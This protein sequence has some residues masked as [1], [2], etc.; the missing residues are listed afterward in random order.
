M[1]EPGIKKNFF[2]FLLL[3]L[4]SVLFLLLGK[5]NWFA[6]FLGFLRRPLN[7]LESGSL[8]SYQRT[9][10]NLS[11]SSNNQQ[12]TKIFELEGRLRQL[13]V[14]QNKLSL[15]QE[16]NDKLKRLLGASLPASWQFMDARVLGI[17][18][19]IK[20]ARGLRDGVKQGMMVVAEDIL[21]GKVSE[22]DSFTSL[23]QIITNSNSK[24]PV[25]IKRPDN[26]GVQAKGLLLGQSGQTLILDKVLQAESIQKG[27]LVATSGDE[28]WLPDLL[29]GQ[30]KEVMPKSAEV[31]QKASVSP[32]INYQDLRIV[33][34]I[35]Q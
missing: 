4:V 6:S 16:E 3:I 27:D 30:I 21:V 35:I 18:D 2:L 32:L 8:A 1:K 5:Q 11:F 12:Q 20:I 15:C 22:V 7:S 31:Y 19:Q 29:V 24:I 26:A 28:N 34:V 10:G 25:V 33:F 23:V 9:F 14:E 13:A 17:T